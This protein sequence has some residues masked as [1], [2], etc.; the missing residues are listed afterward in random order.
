MKMLTWYHAGWTLHQ[1]V[2]R[3]IDIYCNQ[4][5]FDEISRVSK[6]CSSQKV[7]ACSIS[8]LSIERGVSD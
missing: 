2:Q 7:A 1:H 8:G 4:F 5:T 3:S 6:S